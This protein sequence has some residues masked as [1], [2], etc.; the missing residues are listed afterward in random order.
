VRVY[1]DIDVVYI[2]YSCIIVQVKNMQSFGHF[3]SRYSRI[4][5]LTSFSTC[6]SK[7]RN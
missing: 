2:L 3:N 7:K 5:L 1:S 6:H 4:L